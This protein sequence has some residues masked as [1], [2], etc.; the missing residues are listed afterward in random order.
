VV[1][2][3]VLLT[4][5]GAFRMTG[6]VWMIL[7]AVSITTLIGLTYLWL[8]MPLF[9]WYCRRC[10]KTVATSRFHPRRCTCGT[11]SLVAYFCK[12][13]G[14]WN[15]APTPRWHCAVCS[16]QD[17]S[18]GFEYAFATGMWRQRNRNV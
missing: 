5:S 8:R 7:I 12:D 17:V 1:S 11:Q 6:Q 15:T 2:F 16:S 18:L 4:S 3:R 9:R 14:S 13:C 10:K